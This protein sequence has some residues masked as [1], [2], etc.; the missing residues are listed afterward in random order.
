MAVCKP[1]IGIVN[2]ACASFIINN[3]IGYTCASGN[4]EALADLI[5]RLKIEDLRKI[6]AHSKEVY[7]K[8]YSKKFFIGTLIKCLEEHI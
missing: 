4:F 5:K 8:K 1:V 2:G 7:L 3:E 6:G